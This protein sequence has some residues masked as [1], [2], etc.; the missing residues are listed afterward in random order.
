MVDRVQA[1]DRALQLLEEVAAS[2]VPI[3]TPELARRAGVNRATAWRL[4]NSLEYRDLVERDPATGR[5]QV[6]YGAA[7][8]AR[9]TS[10]ES[11]AR[12]ARPVLEDLAEETT[13]SA[14]L[15]V[16]SAGAL[17]V[18]AEAKAAGPLLIDLAG[19][20]VPLHCGSVGKMYLSTWNDDELDSFLTKPLEKFTDF[21]LT[22]PEDLRASIEEIRR[23]GVAFN[24]RD[25]HDDWCG[26]SVLVRDRAQRPLAYLNVTLPTVRTTRAALEQLAPRL[27]VAAELIQQRTQPMP[28]AEGDPPDS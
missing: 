18:V 7:R 28:T 9:A 22:D 21:T 6:G 13:G 3:A 11:L 16:A 12:R 23:T 10:L 17:I 5:Y 19:I 8:L 27:R 20:E 26:L 25:H 15:Q 2:P 24:Y 1:V 4:M 14:F